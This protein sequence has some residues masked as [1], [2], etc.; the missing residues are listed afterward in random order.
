[1][2]TNGEFPAVITIDFES[3]YVD[4]GR[5]MLSLAYSLTG[6]WGDAEDLV[7]EA[8]AAAHRRN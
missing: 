3:F 8:F 7:Q 4:T 2:L 6:N 5:R 1:M